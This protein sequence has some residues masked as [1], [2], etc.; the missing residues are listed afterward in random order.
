[1]P[2]QKRNVRLSRGAILGAVFVVLVF[3]VPLLAWAAG[4]WLDWLWFADLGQ[5]SVFVTRIVSQL[6]V[7]V[8]VALV[9]FALF[10]TNMRIARR[11]APQVF[12]MGSPVANDSAEQLRLLAERLRLVLGPILDS[13]I[14]W[15]SVALA[16]VAGLDMS[17]Q[18]ETFRL[19]LAAVP[20]GYGDP[21]FG[22]DV[23]FFVFTL[24][25]LQRLYSWL[26]GTLL[27]VIVTTF[28]VHLVDGAIQPW[29]RL[30]GFAP[31]V[32]A[33]L[34]VLLAALVLT[35]GFGYWLDIWQLDFSSRGQVI[36]ATYTDV[37]AQ[38]PAYWILIAISVVVSI[39]LLL[40][41]RYKGWRLPAISVGIWIAASI[42]LGWL[43]PAAI[44]QFIVAPNE[45][46][47]EAP[48]IERNIAMTRRA[49]GLTDVQ[50]TTFPAAET[51]TAADI[52]A[53]P[54]TLANVRLWDPRIIGQSYAQLQS[55]RPYYEFADV[56]VD[57]YTI[58][59]VRQQVLVS[60]REMN[61]SLLASQAQTWVNRHLVYTHGFG[62]VVSPVNSADTR[63]MPTFLVGDVPPTSTTDLVTEQPRIYFGERTSEYAIVGG[64][65]KEFDYPVGEKNEYNNYDGSGGVEIGSIV[66]RAAWALELGSTQVLFSGYVKPESR[67]L[68]R[69]DLASRLEALAPFLRY[70]EDPY[71]VLVDGRILWVIDA[72]TSSAFF[73][74]S[75]GLPSDPQT[76]YL[77]NSVKVTVD[78]YDGETT[79][80]AYD[81]SDPI[82]Q[83]WSEVF[84]TLFSAASEI[85]IGVSEHFRYPQGLFSAQAD[86][87]RTY[88]MTDAGVF[89]NKEDQWEIPGVRQGTP[90]EPFFVLMKLPGTELPSFYLMQPFTPRNRDNMI[91]WMAVN[92]DPD[93]YGE[94]TV[95]LF[96]K[97]RVVLGPEQ[98]SARINQDAIISPQLSLWSQR[99]SQAIFGNM[100]VI[101]IKESIVYI[102]PL[103]LQAEQ[104]AIPELTRVIVVYA[105]KV[106]MEQTLQAALLKV[107]GE[108]APTDG[109]QTPGGGTDGGG[110]GTPSNDVAEAQRL[111]EEAI[112]A[113]RAGD[114]ATYGER[115]QQLG[116]V[117]ERLAGQET[118]GSAGE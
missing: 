58:D 55:I 7:G 60:A 8:V 96:P 17:H 42:L 19:A 23:G 113:Q 51:L 6:V 15:G 98:V 14:L 11:M 85:P 108:S 36:G 101:P 33:H 28:V 78:A 2:A 115:I 79:F 116:D 64:S 1:M 81:T 99:G 45:A 89:Y 106:E 56:D 48:Y 43:G 39:A 30:R 27:L 111:Y 91:G 74:Y 110:T 31:H 26:V 20:F 47:R 109:G 68:L 90:M 94:R 3:L 5:Q 73:P 54:Q 61:S 18:W 10:Y 88:H 16:F 66:R 102:Q 86:V 118:T 49:F 62:L 9:T 95:Y 37:H 44:Q 83:A 93:G 38:L 107:F 32:K 21:Q 63:G 57:R 52:T 50:G 25:A 46:A 117:L 105:D 41:I 92:C 59:G 77:R 103:Y 65:I 4:K 40:N 97:E 67:V 29:A 22:R 114:W 75:E 100:L 53:D 24:P 80:Y 12:A 87:Y 69:R 71:A 34:S 35:L 84:P 82:L 76:R 104:T 70:D 13:V 112:A 72:Y